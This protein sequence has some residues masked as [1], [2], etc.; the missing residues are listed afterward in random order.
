MEDGA[1]S[2]QRWTSSASFLPKDPWVGPGRLG[3]TLQL[4][5]TLTTAFPHHG[6]LARSLVAESTGGPVVAQP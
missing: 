1:K 5:K 6:H 3:E 4:C 2:G